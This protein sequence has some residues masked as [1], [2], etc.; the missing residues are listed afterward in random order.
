MGLQTFRESDLATLSEALHVAEDKTSD[1][2]KSSHDL[3]KRNQYDVKT[4]KSLASDDMSSYALAVLR[5][6]ARKG[7]S[8]WES[9]EKNFYFIC[10]QDHRILK[11]VQRDRELAL[12]PFLT[13]ILTHELVH[14]V[15]FGSFLQRY[16]V[17]GA[18]KEREE[19][20]V[21]GITFDILKDLSLRKMDYVLDAYRDHRI[22]EVNLS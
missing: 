21:H 5:R 17:S 3:W 18:N 11:A 19:Q 20:I 16:E 14:I 12:L 7:P 8:S 9:K 6:G 4:I 15:R 2:F 13:Y 10:L 1:F 22:C